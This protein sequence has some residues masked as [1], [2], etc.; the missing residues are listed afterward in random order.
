MSPTHANMVRAVNSASDGCSRVKNAWVGGHVTLIV[1]R[2]PTQYKKK[3]PKIMID[4]V[5]KPNVSAFQNGKYYNLRLG[6]FWQIQLRIERM[7]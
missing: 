5:E 6:R 2:Y 1:Y 7:I 3:L 4:T